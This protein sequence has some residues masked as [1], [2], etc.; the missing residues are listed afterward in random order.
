MVS[1]A[2]TGCPLRILSPV[3]ERRSS[4]RYGRASPFGE[5]A[6]EDVLVLVVGLAYV[7]GITWATAVVA[8]RRGHRAWMGAVLG[9]FLGLIGL[10]LVAIL[11]RRK[12]AY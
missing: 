7:V 1:A 11:P 6:V 10:L 5:E 8:A 3:Q 9:F 2:P 12:P 4:C